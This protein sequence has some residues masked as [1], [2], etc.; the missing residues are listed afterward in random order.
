LAGVFQ[1]VPLAL[2]QV[3]GVAA[4]GRVPEATRAAINAER[5][6]KDFWPE[7]KTR[8]DFIVG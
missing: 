6:K 3:A 2:F 4:E 1:V 5:P 7:E 8:I